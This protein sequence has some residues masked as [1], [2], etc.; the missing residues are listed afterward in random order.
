MVDTRT[1]RRRR[2]SAAILR[3]S[4]AAAP[5]AKLATD[6]AGVTAIEYALIAGLVVVV[7][8]GAVTALGTSVSGLFGAVLDGL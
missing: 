3:R 5:L 6:E 8:V 2:R 1:A 7:M 4:R